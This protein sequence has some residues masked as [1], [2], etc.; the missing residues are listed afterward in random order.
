MSAKSALLDVFRAGSA[1]RSAAAPEPAA[2]NGGSGERKAPPRRGVPPAEAASMYRA[3]RS[4]VDHLPWA[5][6]LEDGTVLLEDGRSVG[7]V[8]EIEPR[9]TEG[10]G[11]AWLAEVRNGLHDVLQDSFEELDASPWVVQTYTWREPDL[12]AAAAAFRGYVAEDARDSVFSERYADILAAHYRGVAK[13]G[14]LF[15]DR[16]SQTRWSGARQRTL[17]VV[18]RWM[19]EGR[20]DGADAAPGAAVLEAGGKLM[21]ALEGL[22]V[23]Q[24]RLTGDEFHAWLTR[25]FNAWT[26]LTPDNPAAFAR[27]LPGRGDALRRRLRR[28]PLLLASAF[29]R[30]GGRLAVR[31]HGDARLER[32][33]AAPPAGDRARHRRDPARRRGQRG[34]RPA[35]RGHGLRDDAGAGAAGHGGRARRPHRVFGDRRVGRCHPRAGGLPRGEGHHGRAP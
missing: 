2:A 12:T 1:K 32:R 3:A 4:F 9:G 26:D 15:A 27:R 5:E 11:G 31:P 25:W 20:G 28:V 14:G 17:V 16:L 7:A 35:A 6:A 10:R 21:G 34:A 8:W 22:G 23:R 29:G 24:R 18:Y 19:R 13:P 33:G 30:G